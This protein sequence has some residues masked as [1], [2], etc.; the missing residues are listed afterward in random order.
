MTLISRTCILML[1]TLLL[2]G[3]TDGKS[4]EEKVSAFC[5]G[6]KVGESF[7]EVKARYSASGL[8]SGGFAP[9]LLE[10]SPTQEHQKIAGILVES[11][12]SRGETR[13][14]CAIYYSSTFRG[15]DGKVYSAEYKSAWAHRY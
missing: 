4:G 1:S 12:D 11:S 5:Q 15:G 13:P 6:V 14:V 7:D 10:S 8:Q 2:S 3:C 9:E